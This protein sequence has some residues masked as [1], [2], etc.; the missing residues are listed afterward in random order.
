MKH[1]GPAAK[2]AASLRSTLPGSTQQLRAQA[3]LPTWLLAAGKS[4]TTHPP[5]QRSTK[6][7]RVPPCLGPTWKASWEHLRWR[8][9]KPKPRVCELLSKWLGCFLLTISGLG[10]LNARSRSWSTRSIGFQL[11]IVLALARESTF[12]SSRSFLG[13]AIRSKFVSSN[14][15]LASGSFYWLEERQTGL[16]MQ[17]LLLAKEYPLQVPNR[18]RSGLAFAFP[19]PLHPSG[20]TSALAAKG[21]LTRAATDSLSWKDGLWGFGEGERST[22]YMQCT[23]YMYVHFL[24]LCDTAASLSKRK[25]EPSSPT[26]IS[27]QLGSA[28]S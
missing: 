11:R 22:S 4:S 10:L 5:P 24:E 6:K 17:T 8:S 3:I 27:Q 15:S 9:V 23:L 19:R 20:L 25:L 13:Q 18:F 2:L 26:K 1:L 12:G 28:E 14:Q 16:Q 7:K 21:A